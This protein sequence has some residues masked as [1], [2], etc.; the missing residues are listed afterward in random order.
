MPDK[1]QA[2]GSASVTVVVLRRNSSSRLVVRR[3]MYVTAALPVAESLDDQLV[4]DGS[5]LL[6][7]YRLLSLTTPIICWILE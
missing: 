7:L 4:V 5:V 6:V 3:D 1:P 2:A